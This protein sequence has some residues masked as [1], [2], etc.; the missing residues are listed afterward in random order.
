MACIM[1]RGRGRGLPTPSPSANPVGHWKSMSQEGLL[2]A[3]QAAPRRQAD[4]LASGA[5]RAPVEGHRPGRALLRS[6]LVR[7]VRHR[8]DPARPRP[9]RRRRA[10]P[11]HARS[12]L[13]IA[14]ILAVVVFSY[15]QTIHAYPGGGGAYIV[16]K[17]NLGRAAGLVAGCRAAH[18]LRADG[19]RQHRGGRGGDD[20]GVPDWHL[21]GSSWRSASCCIAD[22]VGNLRGIRE[23]GPDLRGADL[24][25]H[26]QPCWR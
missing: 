2:L 9:R 1:R 6:A 26:R 24:L 5:P 18:R 16:A 17:E 12:A 25:L 3:A 10:R 11:R 21:N 4:P 15:R 20:L 23:S 19:G 14:T 7:R 13:V 8:G 22:R